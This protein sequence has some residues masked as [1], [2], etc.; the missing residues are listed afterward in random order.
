MSDE[1][2]SSFENVDECVTSPLIVSWYIFMCTISLFNL[3]WFY[4]VWN[5]PIVTNGESKESQNYQ[6]W[7]KWCALPYVI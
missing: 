5:Q 2:V 7:M 4:H 3:R 1:T 6:K